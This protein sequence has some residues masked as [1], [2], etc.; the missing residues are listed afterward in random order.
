[1]LRFIP[2]FFIAGILSCSPFF[3]AGEKPAAPP[4]SATPEKQALPGMPWHLVNL[5][6]AFENETPDFES[7]EVDF[8]INQDVDSAKL[9]L[10]IAPIG[11]GQFNGTAFYGGIQTNSGGW[12]AASIDEKRVR[13]I[14]K[15]AIFSRWGKGAMS[16]DNARAAVDGCYESAGYEGDFVS[17]RRPFNWTAGK[18]T[19]RLSKADYEHNKDGEFTWVSAA[20]TNCDT[21]ETRFVGSLRFPGKTLKFWN[22]SSSFVEIYGG[23]KVEISEL[24]ALEVRIAATPRINGK[25]AATKKLSVVFP[26]E[27]ISASP[28]LM[29]A[30]LDKSADEIVMKLHNRILPERAK[31]R[32]EL[33]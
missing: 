3:A 2:A 26:E 10:Y 15:G 20:V 30:E 7:I 29:T 23:K 19:Y 17:V 13:D 8:S 16:L 4:V 27:G 9:N 11:L 5:W 6:W 22:K 24:P 31:S 25:P 14:G 32:Y 21:G 28:A 1:M 12:P 33:K 18:Y